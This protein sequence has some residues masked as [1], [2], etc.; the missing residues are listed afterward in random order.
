M[1]E[2][3]DCKIGY[4]MNRFNSSLEEVVEFGEKVENVVE[5]DRVAFKVDFDLVRV[6]RVDRRRDRVDE[7]RNEE[8]R[9]R[10]ERGRGEEGRVLSTGKG[11]D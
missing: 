3:E 9:R 5:I 10:V 8:T 4:E 2:L 11:I 7:D 6:V 1:G